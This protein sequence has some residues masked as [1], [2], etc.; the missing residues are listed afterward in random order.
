ME[1]ILDPALEP[2]L[3]AYLNRAITS[4]YIEL[5]RMIVCTEKLSELLSH[6]DDNLQGVL[7]FL[8]EVING[9]K[10]YTQGHVKNPII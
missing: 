10:V 8:T 4:N 5:F 7:D 9:L 1:I 2:S 6:C 3:E